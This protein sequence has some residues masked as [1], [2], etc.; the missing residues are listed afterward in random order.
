MPIIDQEELNKLNS[1]LQSHRED[2]EDIEDE[3]TTIK[4]HRLT[5]I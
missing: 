2:I 3:N 1:Q 5:G 4:K